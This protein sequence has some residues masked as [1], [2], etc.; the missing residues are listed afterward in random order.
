MSAQNI[1]TNAR[2]VFSFIVRLPKQGMLLGD[3]DAIGLAMLAD[4]HLNQV[5]NGAM[6]AQ[7]RYAGGFLDAGVDAQV[8]GGGL[9]GA[10]GASAVK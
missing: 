8:Q 7:G 2:R 5:G 4:Q 3:G 10:H 9:G 6:L 1:A